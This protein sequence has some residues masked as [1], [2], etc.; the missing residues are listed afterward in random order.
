MYQAL[1]SSP[2]QKP[3]NEARAFAEWGGCANIHY[4][5]FVLMNIGTD[6]AVYTIL[7]ASNRKLGWGLGTRLCCV[8]TI[9][10]LFHTAS[11]GKLGG[12]WE[13]GYLQ[14]YKQQKAWMGPGNEAILCTVFALIYGTLERRILIIYIALIQP[15]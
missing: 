11:N 2:A 14:Y 7:T 1:S 6:E 15:V 10:G 8:Y 5:A 4:K 3:E 12:A 13:R 9:P